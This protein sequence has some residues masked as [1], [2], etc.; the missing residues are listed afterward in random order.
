MAG[1]LQARRCR[2]IGGPI[3]DDGIC[4]KCGH[5]IDGSPSAETRWDPD[6]LALLAEAL[7]YR[8]PVIAARAAR[9]LAWR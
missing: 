5:A 8:N 1:T 2:C 3:V 4:L 9:P 7:E 6:A